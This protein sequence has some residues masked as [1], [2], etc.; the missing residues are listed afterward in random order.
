MLTVKAHF[1]NGGF[2]FDGRGRRRHGDVFSID[3]GK[4]DPSWMVRIEGA[5][6][7]AEDGAPDVKASPAAAALA[8][9]LGV[10]LS[11]VAGSG[12]DGTITKSDVQSAAGADW[13]DGE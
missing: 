3:E 4:F 10:D 2:G 6:A 11:T 7:D 5:P 9:E 1:P 8:E 12:K 13:D